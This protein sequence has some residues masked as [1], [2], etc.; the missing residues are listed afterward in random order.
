MLRSSLLLTS[1]VQVVLDDRC[2]MADESGY[3]PCVDG[4]ENEE[5]E[6]IDETVQQLYTLRGRC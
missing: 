6:E 3:K 1:I 4:A 2:N 5:E